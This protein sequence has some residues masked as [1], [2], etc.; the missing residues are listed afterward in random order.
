MYFMTDAITAARSPLQ[1]SV[2][3]IVLLLAS[4][5][6]SACGSMPVTE[7]SGL[8]SPQ[9]HQLVH[10]TSSNKQTEPAWANSIRHALLDLEL[11]VT[12]RNV[13]AAIAIIDQESSFHADPAVPGISKLLQK[14]LDAARKNN[15]LLAQL[16]KL[17]LDS[18]AANGR[19]FRQNIAQIRTEKQLGEWYQEFTASRLT[20]P[21]LA[22]INKD[23]DTLIS[24]V[25]SMQVSVDF[26]R[27]YAQKHGHQISDMR[28]HLFT[29]D[30]GIYYGI[31]HLL[32]GGQ[33]YS[34]M[35]YYFADF[36][37]GHFASR[38]A[39]FQRMVNA[40]SNARLRADG[41]LLIFAPGKNPTDSNS[42][43]ATIR[44]LKQHQQSLALHQVKKDFKTSTG[45]LFS[46]T[47]TYQTISQLHA[48]KFGNVIYASL[49]SIHLKSEKISRKLTTRW[50]A[51]QV[52]RRYNR[53]LQHAATLNSEQA[54]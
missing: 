41:D 13:C 1:S 50:F 33:N 31:A 28:Q 52:K 37:A 4:I 17:R 9:I 35:I 39:G 8:S 6:L 23:L 27:D 15:L 38:N 53:C 45:P 18:Q 32:D 30:G 5:L 24:T 12:E 3:V 2:H 54:L 40:L 36:N 46:G 51:K 29:R 14:K 43:R 34:D 44:T 19:T 11:G 22:L 49:P 10:Q 42:F 7:P 48:G 16:I 21:L 25:G 26:A 47:L 20:Q